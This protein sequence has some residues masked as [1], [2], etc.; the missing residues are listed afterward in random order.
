M[1]TPTATV[2]QTALDLLNASDGL[3]E[4]LADYSVTLQMAGIPLSGGPLPEAP[5]AEASYAPQ[6]L[7]EQQQK[8]AYPVCRVYCDQIRN[9]GKVK[10]REFS[11]SYRVVVAVTHSQDRLEGLTETLQAVADAVGD[12]FD[13]NQGNLGNGMVLEPGYEVQVEAVKKGGLHYIET[14]RVVSQFSWER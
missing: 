13:R 3:A 7:E 9:N 8:I 11:G 12:V 1:P 6:E 10:F 14:A 5:T 2:V 4:S